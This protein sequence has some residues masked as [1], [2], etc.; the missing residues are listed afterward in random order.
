M[1]LHLISSRPKLEK[2]NIPKDTYIVVED[3]ADISKTSQNPF[4]IVKVCS[5]EISFYPK[6]RCLPRSSVPF[7]TS[8]EHFPVILK[9]L[10]NGLRL[11]RTNIF[12]DP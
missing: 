2:V 11:S 8:G 3:C 6:H 10:L 9:P 12:Q 1:S 5:H 7:S 4:S